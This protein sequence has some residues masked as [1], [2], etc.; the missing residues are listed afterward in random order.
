MCPPQV[1]QLWTFV[2]VAVSE[3]V[4]FFGLELDIFIAC[5]QPLE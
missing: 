2:F 3:I 4:H 1:L 5:V